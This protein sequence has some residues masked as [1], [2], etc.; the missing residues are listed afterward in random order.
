MDFVCVCV[1]D[2]SEF[3]V[4]FCINPREF[5]CG[6]SGFA[7]FAVPLRL[8][9]DQYNEVI[10]NNVNMLCAINIEGILKRSDK[11]EFYFA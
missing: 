5:L 7:W 2:L 4:G 6:N 8:S 11:Y 10:I 1:K 3:V 9:Y